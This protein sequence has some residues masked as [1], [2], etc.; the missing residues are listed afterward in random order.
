M[1]DLISM[2]LGGALVLSGYV[3]GKVNR[4]K[5]T[6]HSDPT[7]CVGCGHSL[8]FRDPAT[9]ACTETAKASVYVKGELDHY[10]YVPC[11]CQNHVNADQMTIDATWRRLD[12]P[13]GS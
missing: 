4:R 6:T 1:I 5:P 7:V 10:E 3:L 13:P 8:T 2:G 12:G 9:G 11:G